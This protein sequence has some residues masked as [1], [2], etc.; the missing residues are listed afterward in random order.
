MSATLRK[1]SHG[2]VSYS[3]DRIQKTR[4]YAINSTP[5]FSHP[6][7]QKPQMN[8]WSVYTCLSVWVA[9]FYEYEVRSQWEEMASQVSIRHTKH[10][11]PPY[12]GQVSLSPR[13]MLSDIYI[14]FLKAWNVS[15][16]IEYIVRQSIF[17]II[18]VCWKNLGQ[19]DILGRTSCIIQVNMVFRF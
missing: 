2:R 16:R 17:W 18:T 13:N 14:I 8:N 5:S 3:K 11:S 10:G 4:C 19:E 1:L 7:F 6:K 15:N 12:G 9:T